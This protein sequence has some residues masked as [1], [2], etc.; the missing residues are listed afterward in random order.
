MSIRNHDA[1]GDAAFA[2]AARAL[3]AAVLAQAIR[4]AFWNDVTS[5]PE[6]RR[7]KRDA[8]SWLLAGGRDYHDV[9]LMAGVS[10]EA[11]RE[12]VRRAMDDP[13]EADRLVRAISRIGDRGG[14]LD[15]FAA[16][17]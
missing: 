6:F 7:H 14:R 1:G 8:R 10:P 13:K 9:C 17:A 5:H 11:L 4:D 3:W 2:S 12:R 15:E 16:D